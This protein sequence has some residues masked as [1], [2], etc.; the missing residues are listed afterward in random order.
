MELY[1][2]L[3]MD[4]Q[5][6]I[7]NVLIYDRESEFER[8]TAHIRSKPYI[9]HLNNLI[10]LH[11]IYTKIGSDFFPAL[12]VYPWRD[13]LF[14][15][16]WLDDHEE[17]VLWCLVKSYENEF[18][19]VDNWTDWHENVAYTGIPTSGPEPPFLT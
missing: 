13:F 11:T 7:R 8:A 14:D 4:I 9:Q 6:R 15:D 3:P 2:R 18:Q 5:Q 12:I 19:T 1:T 17:F 16:G 10:A